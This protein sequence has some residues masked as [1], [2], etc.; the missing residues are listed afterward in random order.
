MKLLGGEKTSTEG[1]GGGLWVSRRQVV[2][3]QPREVTRGVTGG[4][5]GDGGG[6]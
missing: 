1:C 3:G 4:G 6:S 2:R 5:E